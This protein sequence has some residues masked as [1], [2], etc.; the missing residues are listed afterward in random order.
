MRDSEPLKRT[1]Q[2]LSIPTELIVDLV[3]YFAQLV[4]E[5]RTRSLEKAS[6]GKF[7]ETLV[8]V[9]QALD[10][11]RDTYEKSVKNV[12]RELSQTYESKTVRSIPDESRIMI[13]RVARAIYALRSKRSQV[14][15]NA[16]NPNAFDLAFILECAQ[17]ILTE[18]VRLSSG[19]SV[20]EAKKLLEDVQR[21][22]VPIL[23]TI[24][25]RDLVVDG[26]LRAEDE[27]LIVLYGAYTRE[28]PIARAEV[29]RA[30]DRRSQGTVSDALKSLWVNRYIEGDSKRGFRLTKL[31]L[32]G[33][34]RAIA[35]AARVGKSLPA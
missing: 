27:V 16:V 20:E 14:H 34:A 7:V 11:S 31:G 22:I 21:P 35:R 13:V 4:D 3:R 29:G 30:M 15:K 6:A 32:D 17:W 1:L 9:L 5:V 26:S 19:L 10:P 12:D 28:N 18:L 25:G 2:S 8:Q 23:E 24:M 33:V